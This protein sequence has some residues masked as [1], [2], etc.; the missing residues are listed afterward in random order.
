MNDVTP[1]LDE[2]RRD[3]EADDNVW[4]AMA[5]GHHQNLFEAAC[6]QLDDAKRELARL[7]ASI[8]E[9]RTFLEALAHEDWRGNMPAHIDKARKSLAILAAAPTEDS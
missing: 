6:E 2:F 3:Y 9:I 1:P 8:A 5:C 4:W 7:R